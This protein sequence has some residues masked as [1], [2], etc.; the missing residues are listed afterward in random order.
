MWDQSLDVS[1]SQ[2]RISYLKQIRKNKKMASACGLPV[3]RVQAPLQRSWL[4]LLWLWFM[5]V[6]AH[7]QSL[8]HVWLL[9]TPW[10]AVRQAPVSTGFSRQEYWSGLPFPVPRPGIEPTSP[11][12]HVD[13]FTGE[14]PGSP[15]WLFTFDHKVLRWNAC[16]IRK[17]EEAFPKGPRPVG[18]GSDPCARFG[19][20]PR[21]EKP[22]HSS[23]VHMCAGMCL[24]RGLGNSPP[25]SCLSGLAQISF[26]FAR[27]TSAR[28]SAQ[29]Y[30]MCIS[31]ALT[32][33]WG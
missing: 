32:L 17:G 27:G 22:C 30:L 11:A 18:T 12:L 23:C 29:S 15:L 25:L 14:P 13:S 9:V 20:R 1:D 5:T 3:T 21:G 6:C 10:L 2:E 26:P 7:A 28:F 31:S 4:P 8:S 19:F 16:F 24:P 33:C